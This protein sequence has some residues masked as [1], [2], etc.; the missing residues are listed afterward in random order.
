M[1]TI[2]V[3]KFPLPVNM[4]TTTAA[5]RQMSQRAVVHARPPRLRLEDQL[6]AMDAMVSPPQLLQRLHVAYMQKFVRERGWG[7]YL[8]HLMMKCVEWPSMMIRSM[9]W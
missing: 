7:A 3:F 6:T 2:N 5:T 1:A 4:A 8:G 9:G